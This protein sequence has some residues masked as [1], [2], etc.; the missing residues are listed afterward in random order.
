MLW[1]ANY[2]NHLTRYCNLAAHREFQSCL[3]QQFLNDLGLSSLTFKKAL[4]LTNRAPANTLL[5][6]NVLNRSR[7]KRSLR[8]ISATE[9]WKTW[10]L[11][12]D[13]VYLNC[14]FLIR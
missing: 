11:F 10:L 4:K 14:S 6:A 13:H 1:D 7:V 3:T 5:Q 8:R 9:F 2:F 12:C